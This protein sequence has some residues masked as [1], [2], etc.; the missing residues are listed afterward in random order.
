VKRPR[1]PKAF[2]RGQ[3]VEFQRGAGSTWERGTYIKKYDPVEWRGWHSVR[4][5]DFAPARYIDSIS[6]AE[7]DRDNQ[8]AFRVHNSI[9]VPTQRL[10]E[11]K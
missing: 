2:R 4:F 5:D 8:Q 9:S 6:G 3:A 7:C 10:R 1:K 11:P